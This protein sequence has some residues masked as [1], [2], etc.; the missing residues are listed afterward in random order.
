MCHWLVYSV[1]YGHDFR[2]KELGRIR[3]TSEKNGRT[4][5]NIEKPTTPHKIATEMK[6]RRGVGGWHITNTA[7]ATCPP[8]GDLVPE[9][10]RTA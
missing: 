9:Y 2:E 5:T 10:R 8:G 1:L 3:Y 7:A 6:I 4:R